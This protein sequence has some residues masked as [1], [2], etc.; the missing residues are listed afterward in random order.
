MRKLSEGFPL[1]A[2]PP[3]L[4]DWCADVML[5]EVLQPRDGLPRL[6]QSLDGGCR[7]L[8]VCYLGG[9]VTEQSSGYRP[10]VTAFLPSVAALHGVDVE[11]V[12]AFCGNCGSKVLAFMVS[13]WVVARRPDL[14]F[15]EL[16]IND[17]DTLLETDDAESLGS[18]LEGIVRHIR[19][20]LPRCE[21]CF[22]YMFL[23]DD[24]PLHQR[25]GSK[26]W[27]E[28]EDAAAARTYHERV[29]RMHDR[30]CDHYG[31]PSIDLVPLMRR[32]PPELRGRLFRDDCHFVEPGAAFAASAI[33]AAL[34]QLLERPPPSS[35]VAVGPGASALPRPLHARPWGRGRAE[36]VT[37]QQL[38]FFYVKA[39]PQGEAAAA[40]LRERL[41]RRHAQ[42]DMDPLD[43][44]RRKAWWLLYAGDS[45]EVHFEG[46]RLGL[47]TMIGPDAGTVRCDVDGGRWS[48]KRTLLDR[49]A[50]FWRLAVVGLVDDL[51]PGRH[52]ARIWM[53]DAPP[54]ARVLK[55]KP[56]GAHWEQ[57]KREGKQHKLWLMHWL[58][59]ESSD[60]ERAVVLRA[61]AAAE[62]TR[63]TPAAAPHA[64]SP[65]RLGG[66]GV[67][68]GGRRA[69]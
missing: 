48:V 61:G 18:A 15:V 3:Q 59:E 4:W 2:H 62:G 30:V 40:E 12:P 16:V 64:P 49:W 23:R 31:L 60:R 28:N 54:D 10:R 44:T 19:D 42:L 20:A 14:V 67:A 68:S 22:L 65:A 53:E 9:S 21:V 55:R 52:V 66:V 58:I 26:A 36:E 57:C 8:R 34:S 13:D 41:L 27:A 33:C 6:V 7:R 32:V 45:A 37:A 39:P 5:S 35:L 46:T 24:L 50:Y 38:S 69:D 56:T 17:G 63:V 29:P 1:L 25:T 51:P 11:E 47:L 43:N